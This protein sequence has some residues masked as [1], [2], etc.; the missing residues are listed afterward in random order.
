MAEQEG[1]GDIIR[2]DP[3]KRRRRDKGP[4]SAEDFC[5]K[6]G[7]REVPLTSAKTNFNGD[8]IVGQTMT[9]HQDAVEPL[10]CPTVE[11][12]IDM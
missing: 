11:D 2:R 12:T 8:P 7:L 6:R 1:L 5:E 10:Q 4:L 3:S 9:R